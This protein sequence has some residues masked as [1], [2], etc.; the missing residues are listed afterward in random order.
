MPGNP[1]SMTART[2]TGNRLNF[3]HLERRIIFENPED[4]DAESTEVWRW[5]V[6]KPESPNEY[7]RNACELK[8]HLDQ[9]EAGARKMIETMGLSKDIVGEAVILAAKF[10]DLGKNRERWQRSIGNDFYPDKMY[11]KSGRLPDGRFLRPREFFKNYR[12]EFG[13]L[14]D[15]EQDA[16]FRRQCEETQELI[17]HLISAHHGRARPHFPQGEAF[18]PD[19]PQDRWIDA[20]QEAPRRY[21]RLT[22]IRAVGS[23]VLGIVAPCRRL[24]G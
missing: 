9:V 18:D 7:G 23:G 24:G 20:S 5:F 19:S 16:E 13:S 4:E 22:Q 15:I 10:H 12:H 1:V 2:N 8:P 6:R 11:A 14:L 3:W 17:R 21:A